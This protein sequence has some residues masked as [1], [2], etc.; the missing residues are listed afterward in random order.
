V[1]IRTVLEGIGA[2]F[3]V[4]PFQQFIAPDHL[5]LYHHGLPITNLIGGALV[6]MMG[7]AILASGFLLALQYLPKAAEGILSSLFA[8]F[9]LWR[10]AD[11]AAQLL[12]NVEGQWF[13]Q[14]HLRKHS[15]IA[16]L[17]LSVL[18]ACVL[19]GIAQPAVR[20]VRLGLAALAFSALWIVPQLL[21]VALARPFAESTTALPQPAPAVRGSSRRIVWILFDELSYDQAFDHLAP[22]IKLPN[23]GRLRTQSVSFSDLRPTGFYTERIIPS[24]LLGRHIEQIRST[25]AGDLWYK[26][27][28]QGSWLAF[29]PNATLFA[30]AQQN[31]WSTGVDG[32]YNPYCH[33]LAPTLN[34]CSWEPSPDF[35]MESFGASEEKSVLTNAAVLPNVWLAMLTSRSAA[36]QAATTE[37]AHIQEYRNGMART[38]ALI[39]NDQIR[40]VFLHLIAPHPPGIYDRQH[41]MLR[42]GG[43]YLDNLVLA[44]DT[45]GA[46]LQQIDATPSASRTTVI[47]SSDHSWRIPLWRPTPGWSAEEE[48]VSGGRFDDRPVLLIHFPGQNSGDEVNAA[49]PELLEH[50]IIAEMLRGKINNS[51]DL[52][53]FLTEHGR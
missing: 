40:F 41:H 29:D 46:L 53:G 32:I 6:D 10:I 20:A 30:L 13:W 23:F 33:I 42:R 44:D 16:I 7:V 4:V 19:P 38:H 35:G 37:E 12:S 39:E 21:H 51:E 11:L 3:L 27:R 48:R 24:L 25:L 8:G 1:K 14:E 15:C 34:D 2:A 17:L 52:A 43:T 49:L 36:I 45:L 26:E 9:M 31:G 28:E 5:V 18:L 22:S 50:D 47:V